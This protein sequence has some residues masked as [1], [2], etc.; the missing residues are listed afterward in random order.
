[1]PWWIPLVEGVVVGLIAT[2]I[3][4]ALWQTFDQFVIP[5][6]EPDPAPHPTFRPAA[7]PIVLTASWYGPRHAGRLTASG[8]RFDPSAH[9]AAHRTLP[10]GTVLR[11]RCGDRYVT[12]RVNDRGP[13]AW[14][15]RDLDLSQAAAE[16][17]GI[18]SQGVA[19]VTVL[20]VSR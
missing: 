3:A 1:M 16:A 9:T 5:T 11:L 2:A 14:T 17:L 18:V 8:E 4:A 7:A 12:V 6:C 19:R 15:G 20:R 10:F 13:E